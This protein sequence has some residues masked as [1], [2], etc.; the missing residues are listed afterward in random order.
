MADAVIGDEN[1][2]TAVVRLNGS[3]PL[4]VYWRAIAR[5]WHSAMEVTIPTNDERAVIS[6]T[7][8]QITMEQMLAEPTTLV[9][10]PANANDDDNDIESLSFV[11]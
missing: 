3:D 2:H 8:P 4:H 1:S 6:C 5:V 10:I 11:Y 9:L 7:I